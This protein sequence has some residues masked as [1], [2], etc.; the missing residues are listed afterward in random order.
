MWL[1]QP[2]PPVGAVEGTTHHRSNHRDRTVIA[3]AGRTLA[4]TNCPRTADFAR[5]WKG[6]NPSRLLATE[7]STY[8]FER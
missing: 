5:P 6:K 1:G 2:H 7:R 4:T 8:E 3:R